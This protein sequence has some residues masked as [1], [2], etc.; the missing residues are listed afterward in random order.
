[1]SANEVNFFRIGSDEKIDLKII[2]MKTSQMKK[3]KQEEEFKENIVEQRI[4]WNF[5]LHL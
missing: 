4:E 1:L 5:S 2:L 3:E